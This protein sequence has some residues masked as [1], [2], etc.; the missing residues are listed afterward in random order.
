MGSVTTSAGGAGSAL[1]ERSDGS[2]WAQMPSPEF[3]GPGSGLLA[4]G[5]VREPGLL[6]GGGGERPRP[7]PTRFRERSGSTHRRNVERLVV[8]ERRNRAGLG[9]LRT[10]GR[11]RMRRRSRMLRRWLGGQL[12][13]PRASYRTSSKSFCSLRVT[14]WPLPMAGSSASVPPVSTG[15]TMHGGVVAIASPAW[16]RVLARPLRRQRV[17][18]RRRRVPRWDDRKPCGTNCR[19][20]AHPRRERILACRL[21]TAGSSATATPSTT[22]RSVATSNSAR[23]SSGSSPPLTG[24]ATGSSAPTAACS[25]SADAQYH[26]SMGGKH[27]VGARRRDRCD[28]R[29]RRLLARRLGRRRVQLRRREISR[30][31]GRKASGG[32][33]RRHNGTPDGN[34]Y[35]LAGSD[36][37]VFSFGDANIW[38][39][40]GW[41]I[42]A[43]P[44]IGIA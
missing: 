29:R 12:A 18:L 4:P 39:F 42:L 32:A 41:K 24:A 38:R 17:R 11:C 1:I 19:D 7:S 14:G 10:P 28:S 43:A 22:G 20:R 44:V 35:W 36:G 34:G 30:I 26:G 8:V 27:L 9:R 31:D 25:A 5:D 23:R 37:G 16:R 3:P 40:H 6:R 2:T 33:R 15:L 21:R 13:Q